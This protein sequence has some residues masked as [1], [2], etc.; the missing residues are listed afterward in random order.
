M[1]KIEALPAAMGG[2]VEEAR[3]HYERAVELSEGLRAS[4]YVS[5]AESVSLPAQNRAEFEALLRKAL[6]VDLDAEP[7]SRLAN[8]I[9]QRRARQL[10]EQSDE[11]FLEP[12]D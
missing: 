4:P 8:R 6:A 10:L 2:S 9:V 12:L 3:R 1:I 5:F 11:L 7:Q